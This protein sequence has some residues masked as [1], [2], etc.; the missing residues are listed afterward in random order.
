[1][2]RCALRLALA[3]ARARLRARY[4]RA[5][6][7]EEMVDDTRGELRLIAFSR[8]GKRRAARSPRNKEQED[9]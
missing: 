2:L 4:P 6:M 8:D 5:V 1:V 3:Q 9:S 7:W